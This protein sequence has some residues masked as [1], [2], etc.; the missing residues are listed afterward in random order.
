MTLKRILDITVSSL[1]L[2]ASLPLCLLAAIGI[3]LSSRGPVIYR[4]QRVGLS[5]KVFVMHKFRTMHTEQGT[6]PSAISGAQDPRVFRLGALLRRLKIDEVPQLYDVLR[7]KMSLIGPRP[8]DPRIVR[9]HYDEAG[10]A[11][12]SVRPGLSSPGSLYY[13]THGEQLLTGVDPETFY[14]ERLLPTKIALDLVYV[15]ETSFMYDLRLL[16]RTAKTLVFVALGRTSF[17]D[18]PELKKSLLSC[19]AADAPPEGFT[20]RR[21]GT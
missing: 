16:A 17:P 15:R 3:R 1:C 21:V 12:L 9:E 18:P 20:G 4:A 2:A 14:V 8:E 19:P 6:R 13:Y 5:G 11:T 7:G 10:H